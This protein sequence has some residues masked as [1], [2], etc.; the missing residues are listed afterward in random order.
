MELGV[1][2]RWFD[3][4]FRPL[5]YFLKPYV[6]QGGW[7]DGMAGFIWAMHCAAGTVRLLAMLWDNQHPVSRDAKEAELRQLWA[8]HVA[9]KPSPSSTGEA[10]RPACESLVWLERVEGKLRDRITRLGEILQFNWLIYNPLVMRYFHSVAL[11]EAPA[12]INSFQALFPFAR[13]YADVGSGTGAYAAEAIRR[14]LPTLALEHNWFGRVMARRQGVESR[15][16]DLNRTGQWQP[17]KVDLAYCIE[18]AEHLS[19]EL[20]KRLV[21]YLCNISDLVVFTAAPPGQAGTGHIHLQPKSYWIEVFNACGFAYDD[22]RTAHLVELFVRNGTRAHWL[23][24]NVM[25]LARATAERD[26]RAISPSA[27]PTTADA[28]SYKPELCLNNA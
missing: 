1:R 23:K 5:W 16:F 17:P 12:V 22:A 20:G 15:H 6:A 11:R 10:W 3:F 8:D 14:G 9:S 13:R 19:P 25:V 7:R 18:V 21:E 4:V 28:A 26:S 27:Q 24:N 2:V